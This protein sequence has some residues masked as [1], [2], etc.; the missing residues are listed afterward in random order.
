RM[1]GASIASLGP[2]SAR[3]LRPGCVRTPTLD[4]RL[5]FPEKNSNR[6]IIYR[7]SRSGSTRLPYPKTTVF[8]K[9]LLPLDL[10]DKHTATLDIAASLAVQAGGQLVLLHVIET[11]PGLSMEEERPFFSRLERAAQASLERWGKQLHKHKVAWQSQILF[12]N[13]AAEIVR[14]AGEMAADLIVLTARRLD[15]ANPAGSL[16]S[17]SYKVGILAR[18]PVLLV[19]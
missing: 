7:E 10:T 11:I 19:K 18:C 12:G 1:P 17:M 4:Q 14:F 13:R 3:R 8:S 6:V 2:N 9:I 5:G 15:E 16:A